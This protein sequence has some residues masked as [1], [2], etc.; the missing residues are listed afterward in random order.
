MKEI[1]RI[2]LPNHLVDFRTCSNILTSVY[3]KRYG[4]G[5]SIVNFP[6]LS[7]DVPRLPLYGIYFRSSF[8]LL[9]VVLS[10]L[11]LFQNLQIISKLVT[12]GCRYHKNRKTFWK[13]FMSYSEFLSKFSAIPFQEYATFGISRRSFTVIYM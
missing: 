8:D 13:F 1:F 4:F 6:L 10:F 3:D 7:G 9:D 12:K 11:F 5:I 2:P